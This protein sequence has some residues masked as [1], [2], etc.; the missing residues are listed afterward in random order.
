MTGVFSTASSGFCDPVRLEATRGRPYNGR[1]M[2][3]QHLKLIATARRSIRPNLELF[4]GTRQPV[5]WLLAPLVGLGVGVAAVLF[6]LAI[7]LVQWPWLRDMGENVTSAAAQQPWW[8]IISAPAAGGLVVGLMLRYLL[9]ARR[10]GSLADV[11]EARTAS[12]RGLGLRQ[13]L[14]SAA[15]TAVSLGSGASA[16]REGPI[17]HLGATLAAAVCIRLRTTNRSCP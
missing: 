6:R 8:I 16:G 13:G 11:I 5:I 9:T 3:R 14:A 2:V 7:G 4:F 1:S 17:A 12:A 10:T 15:A